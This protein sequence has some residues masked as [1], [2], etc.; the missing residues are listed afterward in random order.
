MAS[1]LLKPSTQEFA[2]R[3]QPAERQASRQMRKDLQLRVSA[4]VLAFLTL[5]AVVF[6]GINFWKEGQYPVP[7][8]G[9]WWTETGKNYRRKR[10]ESQDNGRNP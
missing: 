6:A 5:A 1:E 8:D 10:K 4:V 3:K 2:H 9:A 7:T